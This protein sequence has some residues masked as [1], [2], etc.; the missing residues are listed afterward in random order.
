MANEEPQ[1]VDVRVGNRKN[2]APDVA[3]TSKNQE[4]N[5]ESLDG[6]FSQEVHTPGKVI[7]PEAS[8]TVDA[9][10]APT[11]T[12]EQSSGSETNGG[13]NMQMS[14]PDPSASPTS[15]VAESDVD[16]GSEDTQEPHKVVAPTESSGE[17]T[18]ANDAGASSDTTSPASDAAANEGDAAAE[19]DNIDYAKQ[20]EPDASQPEQ[21]TEPNTGNDTVAPE[22][23]SSSENTSSDISAVVNEAPEASRDDFND[24][25]S[26]K[27]KFDQHEGK[28][29]D[30]GHEPES[31]SGQSDA[32]A[33]SE[34]AHRPSSLRPWLLLI[35]FLVTA[36]AGFIMLYQLEQA[37]PGAG[38]IFEVLE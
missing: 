17:E 8:H 16:K 4:V 13:S 35:I 12:D 23:S 38:L 18:P 32:S 26:S 3:S 5:H 2:A 31:S 24:F 29:S 30:A 37:D 20:A 34:T 25:Y 15:V 33:A 27:L 21:S 6:G 14:E 7:T 22:A 19:T 1:K 10:P 36:M 11:G 28:R 9:P